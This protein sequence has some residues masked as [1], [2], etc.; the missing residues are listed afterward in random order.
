MRV[1]ITGSNGFIGSHLTRE[2]ADHGYDVRG[3]DIK[4]EPL[5]Q[6]VS[7]DAVLRRLIVDQEPDIVIHLAARVGRLFGEDDVAET[8]RDNAAMT[9]VV[10]KVVGAHGIRLAYASTSEIYGDC[11]NM[12]AYESMQP[13][14]PHNIYGLSKRW[15]EEV[16]KLYAPKG[17]LV[18][19]FSMPYGPGLPWGRGRAALVNF[20]HQA[21]EGE[22]IP[23][24]VGAERSWCYISDTVAAVRM[25]LESGLDGA[26]NVGRDDNAC[27]LRTVAEK[28]C[29]LVGASHDLIADVPAPARQTIVKRLA[30]EKVR[31]LGWVPV[32]SLD[33]GMRAVYD[34]IV[35]EKQGQA[36]LA[37]S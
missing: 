19:R 23:V 17:L 33:D 8:I 21:M 36:Y 1:L 37:P 10:A 18:L 26:F 25:I 20:L 30:T 3:A 28:A 12:V 5:L 14:L 4:Q 34:W 6:D 29:D 13:R 27:P 7:K 22:A 31:A 24:H 35:E 16:C 32:V 9:A 11:G 2:L 15:G